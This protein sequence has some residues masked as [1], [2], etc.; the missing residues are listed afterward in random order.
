ME[1]ETFSQYPSGP[2][3]MSPLRP[4]C[5]KKSSPGMIL[6]ENSPCEA[7]SEP[8]RTYSTPSEST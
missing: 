1:R 5:I 6:P 3:L 2:V 7:S 4:G 8:L